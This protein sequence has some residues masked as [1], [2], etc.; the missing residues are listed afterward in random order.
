MT[1]LVYISGELVPEHEARISIF[2]SAIM[3]GDTM[4]ES[5]RT[6]R[7]VPFKLDEHIERLYQSLKLTRIDPQMSPA[8]MKRVTLEVFEA[9]RPNYAPHE[10]AWIVHNISRGL[11][12][13]GADRPSNWAPPR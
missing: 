4:T 11:S 7:H 2:D 5:T 3:L 13:A 6:F 12:V 10:D 9:N 8:E 1:R